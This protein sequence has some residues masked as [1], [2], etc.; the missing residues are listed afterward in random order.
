[1][2]TRF[3]QPTATRV[4]T[5]LR[6]EDMSSVVATASFVPGRGHGTACRTGRSQVRLTR[7]GRVV[8]TLLFLMLLMMVVVAF[9]ARSAATDE[10]GQPVKT[11]TVVVHRGDT[12]WEIASTVAQPGEVREMVYRI[13]ELNAL[14]SAAVAEGQEIA[15]PVE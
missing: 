3:D 15:V 10:P 14:P 5:F 8:F 9:S 4:V 13:E 1:M 7:R 11:R 12:L 6:R 2:N